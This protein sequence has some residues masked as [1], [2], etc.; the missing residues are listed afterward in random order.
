MTESR[1]LYCQFNSSSLSEP[2]KGQSRPDSRIKA[3]LSLE[4]KLSKYSCKS[5]DECQGLLRVTPGWEVLAGR[6]FCSGDGPWGP[7]PREGSHTPR[8][9]PGNLHT[10]VPSR[11]LCGRELPSLGLS[12][13]CLAPAG[14]TPW[15]PALSP[16]LGAPTGIFRLESPNAGWP[17]NCLQRP[18]MAVCL[19]LPELALL[20][21]RHWARQGQA[22]H[23]LPGAHGRC[24]VPWAR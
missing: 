13:P 2:S 4:T 23:P 22:F 24:Q 15:A 1:L 7:V 6:S 20:P 18:P 8:E 19:L 21:L 17:S 3:D 10:A 14:R 5:P 9:R 12:A 11:L 16:G